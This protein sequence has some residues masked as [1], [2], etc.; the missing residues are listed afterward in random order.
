MKYRDRLDLDVWKEPP[1]P[2][3]KTGRVLTGAEALQARDAAA[4]GRLIDPMKVPGNISKNSCPE[5]DVL[6]EAAGKIR[7]GSR[8]PPERRGIRRQR[9]RPGRKGSVP[10][11]RRFPG[12]GLCRR[13]GPPPRAP[14]RPSVGRRP[15]RHLSGAG[16]RDA[17]ARSGFSPGEAASGRPTGLEPVLPP[18]VRQTARSF[19]MSAAE[20]RFG[21]TATV[22]PRYSKTS[23]S[24]LLI[25][26]MLGPDSAWPGPFSK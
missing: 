15:A 22:L 26:P 2:S 8:R 17:P 9:R 4:F 23:L 11:D 10:G 5:L 3:G 25:S 20:G 16:G 14:G 7:G 21:I 24:S 13:P 6:V 18:R 1:I 19:F 12:F